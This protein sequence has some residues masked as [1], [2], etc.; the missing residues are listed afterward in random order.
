MKSM[1]R[2]AIAMTTLS[3]L[4]FAG[5]EG[6]PEDNDDLELQQQGLVQATG[7]AIWPGGKIV[8]HVI[9]Q[10]LQQWQIDWLMTRT[11]QMF[12]ETW[13]RAANVHLEFGVPVSTD[14]NVPNGHLGIGMDP[15]QSST[16]L[17]DLGYRPNA[18]TYLH[19]NKVDPFNSDVTKRDPSDFII[20]HEFGHALSFDHEIGSSCTQQGGGTSVTPI[21]T[22]YSVM[23]FADCW[24]DKADKVQLSHWDRIGVQ[25]LYGRKPAGMIVGMNNQCIDLTD[26]HAVTG[27]QLQTFNCHGGPAQTWRFGFGERS[28]EANLSGANTMEVAFLINGNNIAVQAGNQ[29]HDG[30]MR[31]QRWN[32]TNTRVV[33]FGGKCFD[34]QFGV[35]QAGQPVNLA[36]CNGTDAQNFELIGTP[37]ANSEQYRIRLMGTNF[38]VLPSGT[39]AGSSLRLQNCPTTSSGPF[40]PRSEGTIRY[41][42]TTGLCVTA[43]GTD[44]NVDM[45]LRFSIASGASIAGQKQMFSFSGLIKSDLGSCLSAEGNDFKNGTPT[46][47]FTC[48]DRSD[49]VF[50][51]YWKP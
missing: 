6:I 42:T 34:V 4:W 49:L 33:G 38:C 37:T 36:N 40:F 43:V 26:E 1:T 48:V 13:G 35:F 32:L 41:S 21:D 2:I 16:G 12:G 50:D 8:A 46:I 45:P 11:R 25:V 22:Q 44:P 18:P 39:T 3:S 31:N 29:R 28:F 15:N 47:T 51:Y 23:A 10:G 20:I 17:A 19:F 14:A 30:D 5:C 9:T 24:K 7:A 27:Q